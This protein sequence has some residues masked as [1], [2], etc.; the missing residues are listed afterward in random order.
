MDN[1]T[2]DGDASGNRPQSQPH[3]I[4]HANQGAVATAHPSLIRK[5]SA[6]VVLIAITLGVGAT[7]YA[8]VTH[9]RN[10]QADPK[11]PKDP[12]QA[13]N[14]SGSSTHSSYAG[15]GSFNDS[16]SRSQTPSA[17]SGTAERGGFGSSG[18]ARAGSGS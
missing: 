3:P 14:C 10:C 9:G 2:S 7:A 11:D 4:L 12:N 17:S 5:R 18:H 6:A 1:E 15:L 8:A 16:T 13:T